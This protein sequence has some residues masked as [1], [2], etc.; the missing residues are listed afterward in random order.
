MCRNHWKILENKIGNGK[1][2]LPDFMMHSNLNKLSLCGSG[3]KILLGIKWENAEIYM[4]GWALVH[5]AF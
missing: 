4:M 1:L 5:T 2:G 3:L